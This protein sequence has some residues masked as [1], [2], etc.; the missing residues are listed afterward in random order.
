M[1]VQHLVICNASNVLSDGEIVRCLPAMQKW[2]D[3]MVMPAWQGQITEVELFYQPM[4]GI[5][6]LPPDVWPIFINRHSADPGALGWH[7]DETNKIFG[8]IFAGDCIVYKT[9]WTVDLTHEIAEMMGDPS[10]EKVFQM[11]ADEF[12]AFEL[13]DAVESDEQAINVD[14]VL[15]SNFVLPSYFTQSDGGPTFDY[16]KDLTGRCPALT[17]GGYMSIYRGGEWQQIQKDKSNGLASA[18]TLRN[19]FRR[20]LRKLP[21]ENSLQFGTHSTI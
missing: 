15:C 17:G 13:C 1:S 5:S 14:G 7:T 19:G 11:S 4:S 10:A 21:A 12:A 20:S 16:G 8:R 6:R 2:I 9:S 3:N 18:R